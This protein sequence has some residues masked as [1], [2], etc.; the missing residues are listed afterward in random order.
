MLFVGRCQLTNYRLRPI[1]VTSFGPRSQIDGEQRTYQAEHPPGFFIGG[2][3]KV[4]CD[5]SVD[6]EKFRH[7]QNFIRV[8]FEANFCD[9]FWPEEPN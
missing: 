1:S 6:G 5:L 2:V 4:I 7:C 9:F 8:K 3:L